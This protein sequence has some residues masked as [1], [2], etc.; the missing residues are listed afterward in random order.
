[1]RELLPVSVGVGELVRVPLDVGE[2]LGVLDCDAPSDLLCEI[3]AV[4][5]AV[6]LGVG[7]REG[8][9]EWLA[10]V[11]GEG[12]TELY[13]G[14]TYGASGTRQSTAGSG[15]RSEPWKPGNVAGVPVRGQN[16]RTHTHTHT[17]HNQPRHNQPRHSNELGL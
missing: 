9:G 4:V 14:G 12:E 13:H 7:V 11:E 1:M 8:V 5:D 10:P 16:T 2:L 6:T 17:V 3:V 15:H